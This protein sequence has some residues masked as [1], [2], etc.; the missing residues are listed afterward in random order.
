[1]R[2]AVSRGPDIQTSRRRAAARAAASPE[3]AQPGS[4]ATPVDR[5]RPGATGSRHRGACRRRPARSVLGSQEGRACPA[6]RH[7]FEFGFRG[8]NSRRWISINHEPHAREVRPRC[9]DLD[10]R[11]GENGGERSCQP[12]RTERDQLEVPSILAPPGLSCYGRSDQPPQGPLAR[13]ERVYHLENRCTLNTRRHRNVG[14]LTAQGPDPTLPLAGASS[15]RTGCP[16]QRC[17]SA[18]IQ[19]RSPW[20][21]LDKTL[22]I[23]DIS[24]FLHLQHFPL[25][26]LPRHGQDVEVRTAYWPQEVDDVR[27]DSGKLR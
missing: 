22:K 17:A 12:G 14:A 15:R 20:L 10:S 7:H 9:L 18:A 27:Q 4:V 13:L 6:S 2:R 19:A 24:S 1:A 8:A 23:A 5:G 11:S 16:E 26:L 25:D 3:L 21:N